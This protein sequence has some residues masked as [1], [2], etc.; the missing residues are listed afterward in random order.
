MSLVDSFCPLTGERWPW[1]EQLP[2][3]AGQEG[4]DGAAGPG[5]QPTP[6][7]TA[8]PHVQEDQHRRL[9]HR[10]APGDSGMRDKWIEYNNNPPEKI[11]P[12]PFQMSLDT[13]PS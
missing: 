13:T 3:A 5:D 7:G 11:Q 8:A 10:G 1:P 12:L 2:G 9:T 4:G 6:R